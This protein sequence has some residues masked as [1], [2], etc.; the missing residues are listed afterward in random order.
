VIESEETKQIF[1]QYRLAVEKFDDFE[2]TQFG[3]WCEAI[4]N[5]GQDKLKQSLLMR[6]TDGGFDGRGKGL[7]LLRV[8]F[9]PALTKLMR[10]VRYLKMLNLEVPEGALAIFERYETFRQQMGNLDLI[11]HI[12]NGILLT[13]KEVEK[14]M[15]QLKMDK[16]DDELK[17]G[18]SSLTWKSHGINEFIVTTMSLVKDTAK[19]LS[20]INANVA[21]IERYLERMTSEVMFERNDQKTLGVEEYGSGHEAV[22]ADRHDKVQEDGLM[23]HELLIKSN[24]TLR[25]SKGAA[26]WKAYVDY[27]SSI[28]INGMSGAIQHSIDTVMQQLDEEYLTKNDMMPLL[29]VKLELVGSHIEFTP[30]VGGRRELRGV[31]MGWAKDFA[32]IAKLV[33]RLDTGEG[34]YLYEMEEDTRLVMKMEQLNVRMRDTEEACLAFAES[35]AKFSYLWLKP[36][37]DSFQDFLATAG[38]LEDPDGPEDG[39]RLPPS[40][41]DF[42]E[43]ILKYKTIQ[44]EVG[45]L[46]NNRELLW[47]KVDSKPIKHE[48]TNWV[49]RWSFRYTQHLLDDV[50]DKVEELMAFIA[51]ST[52]TMEQEV[53]DGDKDKLVEVMG[54]LR[55]VR[56]RMESTDAMFDPLRNTTALLKRWGLMVSDE[57]LAGLEEAPVLWNNVKKQYFATN[58]RLEGAKARE[59]ENIKRNVA[60]FNADVLKFRNYVKE[61]G[62]FQY[63]DKWRESYAI[64]SSFNMKLNEMEEKAKYF[65]EMQDLFDLTVTEYKDIKLSRRETSFLKS[66]WDMVSMVVMTFQHYRRILWSE[67]DVDSLM[68]ECKKLSKTVRSLDKYV[69]NWPVY[70]DLEAAVKN[71]ITSLPLVADLA[72]PSMRDRHWKQL[73]RASG[74]SFTMDDS[75]SLGDLLALQLHKYV[76]EVAEIVDKAQKE[77][78]IEKQL[79]KME[80]TWDTLQLQFTNYGETEVKLLV[81]PEELVEALD[82]GQVQLQALG[83]S[84]Y[85][86]GNQ[87]FHDQVSLWQNKLGAVDQTVRTTWLEVQTKWVGLEPIFI[88]SADIRVQ[89]PQDSKRFDGI[90]GT[91]K[92]MMKEAEYEFNPITAALEDERQEMLEDMLGKLELCEKSLND[93][94]ETKR[95]AFP[96]FYFVAAADLL[97]I[98]SKGSMPWL[99]QKHFSKNFDSIDKLNFEVNADGSPSKTAVAMVSPQKEVVTFYEP[100]ECSGPVEVW[101]NKVMEW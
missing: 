32:N 41:K 49:G 61:Q 56:S 29:E 57:V 54:C 34:D 25:I 6:Y 18:C 35:Y 64:L 67:I 82:E 93:Y 48:I 33:A 4:E 20:Q 55:D 92:E 21:E 66:T 81:L 72:H 44:S 74:K 94:L 14:P 84:K 99:L 89:L 63:H 73:M 86:A 80:E 46:P 43:E 11:A 76:E 3:Q 47:L 37:E 77:L 8:N 26:S 69:K 9:D 68:D 101:L 23:I 52:S 51:D 30:A 91:W 38:E 96:R 27:I 16:I 75:F 79:Q 88:G 5:V 97:D 70:K 7:P 22:I 1:S 31:V 95:V 65:N 83:G 53:P 36:I 87:N 78:N 40:L 62:P 17:K 24:K 10:E 19:I 59:A 39:P 50:T 58:Q 100:L 12:Y 45:Q 2:Q 42:D 60:T 90:D 13:L 85:V 28:V 71:M 98:L 15:L